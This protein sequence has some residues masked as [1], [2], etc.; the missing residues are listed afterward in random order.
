MHGPFLV[1]VCLQAFPQCTEGQDLA[2]LTHPQCTSI[3]MRV[4]SEVA[5]LTAEVASTLTGPSAGGVRGLC[6]QNTMG[7]AVGRA[8]CGSYPAHS[9]RLLWSDMHGTA[10]L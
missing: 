4:M 5:H 9:I 1:L 6:S 7:I 8:E 10:E 3:S 2:I